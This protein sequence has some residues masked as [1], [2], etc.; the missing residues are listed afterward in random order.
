MSKDKDLPSA[1]AAHEIYKK[2]RPSHSGMEAVRLK[3]M[4]KGEKDEHH[5][6]GK[7]YLT[8]AKSMQDTHEEL[9][10][11][12]GGMTR[13][14][15]LNPQNTYFQTHRNINH[16][17]GQVTNHHINGN[18]AG[19]VS[20]ASH[21]LNV[22][23]VHPNVTRAGTGSTSQ[24]RANINRVK[25]ALRSVHR[26]EDHDEQ[27]RTKA[28]SVHAEL[29]GHVPR[30]PKQKT[31]TKPSIFGRFKRLFQNE[32]QTLSEQYLDWVELKELTS[33]DTKRCFTTPD[34]E[35]ICY[36]GPNEME[37][38]WDKHKQAAKERESKK[39]DNKK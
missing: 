21:L 6:R 15:H 20:H 39:K 31:P 16:I 13:R 18:A 4:K 8:I 37:K 25:E 27:L 38:M 26:N 3:L 35:K 36:K 34:G 24:T 22:L 17:A 7:E 1:E 11:Y 14:D 23:N 33:P 19:V 12:A 32:G 28:K 5:S 9:N 29:L 2:H 30:P 10:E